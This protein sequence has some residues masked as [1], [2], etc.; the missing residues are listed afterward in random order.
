MTLRV[1]VFHGT[2]SFSW[3]SSPFDH[4]ESNQRLQSSYEAYVVSQQENKRL[5]D[6]STTL[7]QEL[8]QMQISG[9][10]QENG[11]LQMKVLTTKATKWSS[12]LLLYRES[13]GTSNPSAG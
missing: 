11:A 6:K 7:Q 5:C 10:V 13:D 3:L 1:M 4:Q 9:L 12:S 2:H 8:L